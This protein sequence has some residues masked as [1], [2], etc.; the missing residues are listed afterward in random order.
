M[1]DVVFRKEKVNSSCNKLHASG[2]VNLEREG[3]K[4]RGFMPPVESVAAVRSD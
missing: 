3:E 1:L 2:A 4:S